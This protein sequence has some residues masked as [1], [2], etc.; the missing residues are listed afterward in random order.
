METKISVLL[1]DPGEQY[2]AAYSKAI[3]QEIGADDPALK[4][5]NGYDLNYVVNSWDGT[6]RRV[7]SLSSPKTGIQMDVYTDKPGV[8]L[9]TA[10]SAGP[11]PGKGG[12][13]YPAHAAVC[14]ETQFFPDTPNHP[15][16][17]GGFTSPGEM[18]HYTTE[19]RF[20]L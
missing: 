13:S 8:Q 10:N 17:P 6:M 12:K 15:E 14:L 19:Y 7:A 20:H 4:A 11:V 16:F 3:G 5:N 18:Y 2:R 1:A 9:F